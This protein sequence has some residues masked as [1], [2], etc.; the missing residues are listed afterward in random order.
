MIALAIQSFFK[1]VN[2]SILFSGL[3]KSCS[4]FAPSEDQG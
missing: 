2:I 4:S 1:I 3:T